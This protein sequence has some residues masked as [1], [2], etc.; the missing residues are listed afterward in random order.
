MVQWLLLDSKWSLLIFRSHVQ[1]RIVIFVPC[2][3]T[4]YLILLDSFITC[5]LYKGC[6]DNVN[7]PFQRWIIC[8]IV[9]TLGV[10][11][12]TRE[13]IISINFQVCSECQIASLNTGIFLLF[14]TLLWL[15]ITNS[16]VK[17]NCWSKNSL[18]FTWYQIWQITL[19][20][21]FL[22]SGKLVTPK[23]YFKSHRLFH[24]NIQ[25]KISH[26]HLTCLDIAN[27]LMLPCIFVTFFSIMHQGTSMLLKHFLF[28][29]KLHFFKKI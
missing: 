17:S 14:I 21:Q 4:Q 16:K 12:L 19:K 28:L 2:V 23:C 20:R 6:I 25:H 10:I 9:A 11:V 18:V 15:K 1:C 7:D 22:F 24:V 26:R 3:V 5:I 27:N 8:L 29:S 13:Y